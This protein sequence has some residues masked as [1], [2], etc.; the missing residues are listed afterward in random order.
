MEAGCEFS[1]ILPP[2]GPMCTS[3]GRKL[4][5]QMTESVFREELE[6]LDIRVQGVMRF[7][8][9][10]LDQDATHEKLPT[11]HFVVTVAM[12]SEVR[13]CDPFLNFAAYE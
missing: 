6:T 4:G 2:I 8:F 12:G 13:R 9:G 11:P 10:R 3:A 7:R 5:R 1:Q